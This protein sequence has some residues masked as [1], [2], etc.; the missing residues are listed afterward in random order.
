MYPGLSN[1]LSG[2]GTSFHLLSHENR[3]VEYHISYQVEGSTVANAAI[4][5]IA[6]VQLQSSMCNPGGR[7]MLKSQS[8]QKRTGNHINT[9]LTFEPSEMKTWCKSTADAHPAQPGYSQW[10]GGLEVVRT[11]LSQSSDEAGG[12]CYHS[13]QKN[14]K[15]NVHAHWHNI[16]TSG[17]NQA[18]V[19]GAWLGF[20]ESSEVLPG[21]GRWADGLLGLSIHPWAPDQETSCSVVADTVPRSASRCPWCPCSSRAQRKKKKNHSS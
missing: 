3:H 17:I 13:L 14:S 4:S 20:K 16:S 8:G 5:Q 9:N 15:I 10:D 18:E 7:W 21:A 6:R 11:L 19:Y 1:N 12:C 2:D